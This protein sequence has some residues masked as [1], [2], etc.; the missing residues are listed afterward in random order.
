MQNAFKKQF[1]NNIWGQLTGFRSNSKTWVLKQNGVD[2]YLKT[3]WPR[4]N[5]ALF[6]TEIAR[7]LPMRIAFWAH[8]EACMPYIS[9]IYERGSCIWSVYSN[10]GEQCSKNHLDECHSF[11]KSG[12]PASF[13]V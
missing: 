1:E 9:N 12:I 10:K 6:W 8:K 7:A 2:R 4:K 3:F 11:I 5:P 13:N